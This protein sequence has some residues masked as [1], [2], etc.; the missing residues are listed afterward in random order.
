MEQI[1]EDQ[2]DIA[3]SLFRKYFSYGRTDT[4]GRVLHNLKTK[5]NNYEIASLIHSSF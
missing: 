3:M 2:K 4:I 1:K 5:A